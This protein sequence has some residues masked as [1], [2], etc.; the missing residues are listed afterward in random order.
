MLVWALVVAGCLRAEPDGQSGEV[1]APGAPHSTAGADVCG[2]FAPYDSGP[3][4][5]GCDLLMG[6]DIAP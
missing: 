2:D 3:P 5:V 6:L 4:F 1:A